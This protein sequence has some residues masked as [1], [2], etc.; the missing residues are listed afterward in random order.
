[1]PP[2]PKNRDGISG[3]TPT[4]KAGGMP[5]LP[6]GY[7]LLEVLL[8]IGVIAV[9]MGITVPYLADSFGKTPGEE[10]ADTVARTVQDVRASAVEFGEA[11]R[12]SILETGLVPE[13]S[14]IPPARLPGGWK[15]EVRRL[16]ESRFRKPGK[17]ESWG[18]NGAGICEPLAL[19]LRCGNESVEL[20]FDPLTGLVI[21]E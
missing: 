2:R 8:A 19:R 9:L 1:M 3:R 12:I 13:I 16:T 15:L 11:R 20:A 17:I 6:G 5:A 7:T 4:P 18:F 21:D 10:I 14:S